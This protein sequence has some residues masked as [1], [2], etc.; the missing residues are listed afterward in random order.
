[1]KRYRFSDLDSTGPEHV[2]AQLIPGRRIDHGGLSFHT[3]G[4]RTHDEGDHRH[5]NEEVFC[6]MQGK[7]SIE[8]NG[9]SEPIH[10]GDV[11]VIEPGEDH[12]IVG[13]PEHP[14]VNCWFHASEAGSTKQYP[15]DRE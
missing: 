1:M 5:D 11:L 3:P 7:G 6:I 15:T 2:A 4:M 10:A 8:I 14:I 13:D 12:H 9:Q